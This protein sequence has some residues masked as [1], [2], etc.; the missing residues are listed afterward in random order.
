MAK[1]YSHI[2]QGARVAAQ[3]AGEAW[4]KANTQPKYNVVNGTRVVG[5]MLDVCGRCYVQTKLNTSFA[6]WAKKKGL[7]SI[8]PKWLHFNIALEGRQEMGLHEAMATAAKNYL[9]SQGVT[10]LSLHSWID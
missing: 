6:K 8:V 9:E 1:D 7:L 4:L 2:W 10:G 5:Q 3:A